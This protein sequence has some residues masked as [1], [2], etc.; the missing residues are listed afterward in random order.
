MAQSAAPHDRW[1]DRRTWLLGSSSESWQGEERVLLTNFV[2]SDLRNHRIL[3]I[4]V[5]LQHHGFGPAGLHFQ[6]WCFGLISFLRHIKRMYM[7]CQAL[8]RLKIW[9][10]RDQIMCIH[11]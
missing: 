1:P 3:F 4:T 2:V 6:V 5:T 7:H 10:G 9:L 8:G 11:A